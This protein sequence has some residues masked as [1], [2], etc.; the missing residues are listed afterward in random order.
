MNTSETF[1]EFINNLKV[2]NKEDISYKFKRITK[3]LNKAFYND[4]DSE[5]QHSLQIG[6]YGRNTAID[7][8]S[9]LD[10]IF[11][12]SDED[13]K[14][15]NSRIHNGQSDLLQDTKKAIKKTYSN[16][17]VRGDG[18]VVVVNFT[19]YLI[20]VCPANLLN[21]KSYK[22]P[23]SKNGGSWKITKPRQ[24]NAELN[25]FNQ[26]TNSNLKR[27]CKTTRAWK[28]KNGVKM[29][30][31]LIDTFCYNFL[32]ANEYY[33]T[34]GYSE[35]DEL[36]KDFFKYVSELSKDQK[37]WYA[38]GSNQKVFKKTN[39]HSKAKKAFNNAEEAINKKDNKNVYGIWRKVFGNKFPYPKIALESAE[40]YTESEEFIENLYPVDIRYNL[41][42]D[43]LVKQ[44]GFRDALLSSLRILRST[45]KLKFYITANEVPKPY[46]VKWK[47]KNLGPIAQRK[48]MLRGQIINDQG[49]EIRNENSNFNGEHYVECFII[50]NG[51]CVASDRIDVPISI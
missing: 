38:P 34:T 42:I 11:E 32:K 40:N 23:D 46:E 7:G 10:M 27:L 1:K 14:K 37:Y 15:Y 50:K 4:L 16:T 30:G 22:Y 20:E 39:F 28:N 45:K 47:I 18:Q 31:L 2:S 49:N 19:N 35:F 44:Q 29:G 9:D 36:V 12:I 5:T 13:F 8:I 33:H 41:N 48:N 6:S 25:T 51:V 26:T 21:D 43:C 3:A 17:D 24:E